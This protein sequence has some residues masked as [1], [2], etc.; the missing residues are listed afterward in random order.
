VTASSFQAS[1][2]FIWAPDRDGSQDDSAPG[3]PFQ[4]AW[5]ITQTTWDSSVTDG[6]VIGDL[7]SATEDQCAA[8]YRVRYWN[9]MHASSLPT[10]VDLMCFN[11]ATLTGPGHTARLLQRTVGAVQDGAIGPDTLRRVGSFGVKALIDTLAAAD[12]LYLMTL[13]NAPK[14]LNG[15]T[16][17]ENACRA[18][19]YKIARIQA[20]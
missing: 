15:W 5:G 9:A 3:E 1:L 16:R 12:A 7:T 8:I 20:S 17:R 11:D 19:A 18:A 4:T 13:A 6:I 2:D 14:F 10:G